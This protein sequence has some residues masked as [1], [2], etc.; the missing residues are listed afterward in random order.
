MSTF[1]LLTEEDTEAAARDGW[2]IAIV[3]DSPSGRVFAAPHP[4]KDFG[5]ACPH[6]HGL[7]QAITQTAASRPGLARRAVHAMTKFNQFVPPK[8]KKK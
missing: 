1:D 4:I 5:K 2:K 3:I 8:T 7:L 6:A